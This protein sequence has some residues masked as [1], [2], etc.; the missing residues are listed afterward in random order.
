M[1]EQEL[2]HPTVGPLNGGPA[3]VISGLVSMRLLLPALDSKLKGGRCLKYVGTEGL[4]NPREFEFGLV[5]HPH[6]L[7]GCV[8]ANI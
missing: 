2:D 7:R 8:L 6:S 3:I 5:G 4:A 1:I